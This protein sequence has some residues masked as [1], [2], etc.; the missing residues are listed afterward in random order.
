MVI[1]IDIDNE[2][3]YMLLIDW[4]PQKVMECLKAI[5]QPNVDHGRGMCM[6]EGTNSRYFSV[7]SDFKKI[8]CIL[9]RQ[10]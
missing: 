1:L 10:W 9:I 8:S 4:L 3:C 7:M 2:W 6:W 5:H